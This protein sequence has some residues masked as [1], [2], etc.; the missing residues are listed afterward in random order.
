M[1]AWVEGEADGITQ[2]RRADG[3]MHR[4]SQNDKRLHFGLGSNRRIDRISVRWPSGKQ[5]QLGPIDADRT[6]MISEPE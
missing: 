1:R 4:F 5:Q 2:V 6:L 3:G